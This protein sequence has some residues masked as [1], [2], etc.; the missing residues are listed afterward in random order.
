[1]PDDATAG[2]ARLR[3]LFGGELSLDFANTVE[4]RAAQPQRDTLPSYAHL[5]RW[6]RH[7]GALDG[8][9]AERLLQAA[10]SRPAAART[11][12]A[13]AV[14]LREAIYR[15]FAAI[16]HGA[17]PA[18][19]DLDR[20]RQGYAEAMGHARLRPGPGQLAWTWDDDEAFD[21]AWWPLARSAVELATAGPLDR[22]KQCAGPSGCGFLF[23]DTT[24]NRVRR[25]CSMGECGSQVKASRQTARRRAARAGA[26]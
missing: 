2:P 4:P 8:A 1:M 18:E 13:A 6:A 23:L 11:S 7:A 26:R 25:W 9:Q 3:E 22:V 21:R 10:A 14:T 5:V 19:A 16:A 15:V 24:K 12:L 20:L 17:T